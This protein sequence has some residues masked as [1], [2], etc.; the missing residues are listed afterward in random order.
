MPGSSPAG[1]A[2][3]LQDAGR[4]R[5]PA[6]PGGSA[7][8]LQLIPQ[9]CKPGGA[10]RA[11]ANKAGAVCA[12]RAPGAGTVV[13]SRLSD[14]LPFSSSPC[15]AQLRGQGA[16]SG[17]ASCCPK[18]GWVCAADAHLPELTALPHRPGETAGS[19]WHPRPS[20][21]GV[22]L[23]KGHH[24]VGEKRTVRFHVSG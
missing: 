16:S 23:R 21:R 7:C 2:A 3:P 4:P 6:G 19:T 8:Q 20:P 15:L 22:C 13:S 10:R 18:G 12:P 24:G 14:V 1:G 11:A 17:D 5:L 9:I